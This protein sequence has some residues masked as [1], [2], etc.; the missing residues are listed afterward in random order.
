VSELHER[1]GVYSV[2]DMSSVVSG[3]RAV[4]A[5]GVAARAAKGAV[6]KPVTVTGWAAGVSA[7]GEDETAGMSTILKLLFENGASA[8]TAV[9]VADEGGTEDYARAFAALGKEEVRVL[10][11]DS[12]EEDV[13]RALRDAVEEASRLRHERI[14]VVGRAGAEVSDLIARAEALNS[15]RMV[16]VAPGMEDGSGGALCAA[17]VAGAVAG[18]SD[19]ALPLGGA[20]LYGLEGLERNYDDREVNLL[21]QGGVTALEMLAGSCYVVRGVTTRTKTGGAADAT[22][23]E[24]STILVVDE[25]IPGIRSALRAKFSRAKNTPQSRGAIRSLVVMELEKRVGREVI[26]GYEDVTVSALDSDPTVCLVEFAFTVAHGLNQVW[27]SAHI[28]V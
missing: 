18:S 8:V 3:G 14:A 23:R 6:D 25:V 26:D 17:A 7:F 5:I 24:L 13:Q 9:R 1:P 10:V 21:V 28:T 20:Q 11:C 27:L 2:Y 4:Q 22:W 15:E 16:L 12:G 19:P